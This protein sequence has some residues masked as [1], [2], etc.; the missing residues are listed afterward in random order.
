M[1]TLLNNL[2][3]Y[4]S[5]INLVYCELLIFCLSILMLLL[6]LYVLFQEKKTVTTEN[7][8]KSKKRL[9]KGLEALLECTPDIVEVTKDQNAST[10]GEVSESPEEVGSVIFLIV[11][12]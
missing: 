2:Y 7:R 5:V 9:A 3:V 11:S 6:T 8:E 1:L 10:V 12:L 4:T